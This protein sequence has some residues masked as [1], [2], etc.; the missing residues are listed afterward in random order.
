MYLKIEKIDN[1]DLCKVNWA[2]F[3]R[4]VMEH[5]VNSLAAHILN[6]FTNKYVFILKN[7]QLSHSKLNREKW[8][9]ILEIADLFR[10]KIE[11]ILC[12]GFSLENALYDEPDLRNFSD[13]DILVKSTNL[14][15]AIHILEE[16]DYL[17]DKN[18]EGIDLEKVSDTTLHEIKFTKNNVVVEIKKS[19]SAFSDITLDKYF[20]YAD[21]MTINET[22]IRTFDAEFQYIH[23]VKNTYKEFYQF[24]FRNYIE[25]ML[26]T[27]LYK[28]VLDWSKIMQLV[29]ELNIA[30]CFEVVYKNIELIYPGII[31]EYITN[32]FKSSRYNNVFRI[33]N[34]EELDFLL[35]TCS[36][37]QKELY[38]NRKVHEHVYSDNNLM[39]GSI[40]ECEEYNSKQQP[41]NKYQIE[42]NEK[43]GIDFRYSFAVDANYLY[44]YVFFND[45]HELNNFWVTFMFY[46]EKYDGSGNYLK[47]VCLFEDKRLIKCIAQKDSLFECELQNSYENY[48][49]NM[50]VPLNMFEVLNKSRFIAYN[51]ELY[52][53]FGSKRYF[54]LF[55]TT[56][57][58]NFFNPHILKVY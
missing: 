52:V 4:L 31:D 2:Q 55:G 15:E 7:L 30:D 3:H 13:I 33:N 8:N 29:E 54:K 26:Y 32:L 45:E 19:T 25:V 23:L 36:K 34:K 35:E 10:F 24:K 53:D 44:V 28:D 49:L 38:F 48:C 37:E 16:N 51:T 5:K 11:Y 47:V 43:Y 20:K 18:D 50:M 56:Y 57:D 17:L 22:L 41:I 27:K 1:F 39:W 46:D 21:Y 6:D 42:I 12:K 40:L 9:I 14:F 58:Y